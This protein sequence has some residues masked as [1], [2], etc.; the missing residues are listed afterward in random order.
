VEAGARVP[1][2]L[3]DWDTV[4]ADPRMRAALTSRRE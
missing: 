2:E 3:F 4:R 1:P